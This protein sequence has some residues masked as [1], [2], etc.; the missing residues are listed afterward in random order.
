MAWQPQTIC[1]KNKKI[2]KKIKIIV[3]DDSN[4]RYRVSELCELSRSSRVFVE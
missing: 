3:K 4:Y 2:K 1:K